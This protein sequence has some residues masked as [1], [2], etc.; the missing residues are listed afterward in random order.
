MSRRFFI[1]IFLIILVVV[2]LFPFFWMFVTS[3]KPQG[4]GLSMTIIPEKPT[5]ENFKLVLT[6]YKF[7]RYFFNSFVV[8]TLGGIFSTLFAVLAAYSF[9]KR[10]FF[11]RNGLF[12]LFLSAMMVPGMMFMIPQ[13]VIVS[14]LGWI[15]SY[16][17]MVIPHLA[18]VFGLFLLTQFI[19]GI[20]NSLI[21][22]S[23]IDGASEI[24][25]IY[26]VILPL[27]MPIVATVFLLSFQFNW[28]NFLWQLIVTTKESMYTVPVGLAMFRSAHEELY[29]LR[30]AASSISI[31]PIVLLFLFTQR[32][33]IQGLTEGAV[34][35]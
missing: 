26:R 35:G 12:F 5:L 15:N 9:A 8:S 14:R 18:N 20:P 32:Y 17:A 19:R 13:F 6:Q 29:T 4:T 31:F 16:K 30:M 2:V 28:N 23:R 21:E 24:G 33:F 25:V 27:S 10:R 1:Y 11:F 34:K 7:G 22:A 3:F